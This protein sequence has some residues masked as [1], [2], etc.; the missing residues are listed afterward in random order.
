MSLSFR[1]LKDQ[2]DARLVRER[3]LAW[4]D[5]FFGA[6]ALLLAGVGL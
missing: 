3:V 1:P 5:G 2:V 6:L 4:L